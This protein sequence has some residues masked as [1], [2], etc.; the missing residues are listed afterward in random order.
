MELTKA[1]RPERTASALSVIEVIVFC[2]NSVSD[3]AEF[4]P[5]CLDRNDVS[6]LGKRSPE[7]GRFQKPAKSATRATDPGRP[8]GSRRRGS[9]R[10]ASKPV[11]RLA[12]N[13][14]TSMSTPLESLIASGTKLWLDGVD[15]DAVARNR[16]W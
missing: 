15:P 5:A 16:D 8:G 9:H 4:W 12:S 14:G 6:P 13:G 10:I 1:Y 11:N 2:N 3:V 7:N